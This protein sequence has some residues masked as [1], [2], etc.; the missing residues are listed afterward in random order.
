MKYQGKG[1]SKGKMSIF[2]VLGRRVLQ[3]ISTFKSFTMAYGIC[4]TP[5]LSDTTFVIMAVITMIFLVFVGL[6]S[7]V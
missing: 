6:D 1:V 5:F 7:N 2:K 4:S 3:N